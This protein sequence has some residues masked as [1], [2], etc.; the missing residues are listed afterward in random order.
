[1][2]RAR[3]ESRKQAASATGSGVAGVPAERRLAPARHRRAPRSRRCRRPRACAAA[4][5][6]PGSRA[7]RAGRGRAP[8][9]APVA[10][11]AALATP[12]QSY[13]GQ[14]T[15]ASKSRATIEPPAV[16][17]SNSGSSARGQRLERVGARGEGRAGALGR[18]VEEA[19]AERVGRARTRWRAG[20]R[21]RRPSAR[22]AR[23]AS[24]SKSSGLFTSSSSTSG[25]V[26]QA[27][28]GALGHA[29]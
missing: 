1:M 9:S 17:S 11:S 20:R 18:R 24:A 21:P 27:R 19:A 12:I 26:R 6:R 7:R 5:R 4:R 23:P 10:S 8:G 25:G 22:A 29:P 2:P 3:S 28:R 14:A 16:A 15:E 13:A